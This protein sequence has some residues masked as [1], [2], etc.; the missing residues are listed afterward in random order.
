MR[1]TVILPIYNEAEI[2]GKVF[3]EVRRFAL[4]NPDFNFVFVDDGSNDGTPQILDEAVR[5]AGNEQFRLFSYFPNRGK[6][7]AV[8]KGVEQSN[9]DF[10]CFMDGDLAYS[11]DHLPLLVEA[12][13]SHD[14]VI[15]SRN[16]AGEK[17]R[18]IQLTRRIMGWGFNLLGQD[19]A[20]IA[21]S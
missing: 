19:P 15:G 18:N 13:G 21:L 6:G 10:I 1:T 8:R 20:Q 3:R 17:Q 11:L 16:L 9:T 2:I 14:V 5:R 12:L 7:F 4:K